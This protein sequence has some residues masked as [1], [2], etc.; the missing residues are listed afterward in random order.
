MKEVEWR[1]VLDSRTSP[2]CFPAETI[3]QAL[4]STEGL[5]R[6]WYEGKMVVIT[7]AKGHKLRGT[8]NHPILTASGWLPLHEIQPGEQVFNAH[9]SEVGK[10]STD[11]NVS[12]PTSLGAISDALNHPAVSDVSVKRS[13][14][15]DFHG[16]GMG[17][18][19]EVDIVKTKGDLRLW[20]ETGID[21][22]VVHAL[23][24]ARHCRPFLT[25][26]G[27]FA[28]HF[29][30]G[31]PI[32]QPPEVATVSVEAL[33]EPAFGSAALQTVEDDAGPLTRVEHRNSADLIS[34]D[35]FIKLAPSQVRSD[36]SV[37]EQGGD[38]GDGAPVFFCELPGGDA[39]R[40]LSD[41][42]VSV[43]IEDAACHVYNLQTSLGYYIAG[44]LIVHNCQSR[45]GQRYPVGEG[46]RPPA[47]PGCRSIVI[48][49]LDGSPPP[50][51][52]TYPEWI[53]RQPNKVQD[54]IL[55]PTR[56]ELLRQGRFKVTE[57]TDTTGDVIPLTRLKQRPPPPANA[58]RKA[59]DAIAL[60]RQS[61][62]DRLILARQ[63][64]GDTAVL[65]AQAVRDQV[66]ITAGDI[67]Q[68]LAEM[69]MALGQ[70][71]AEGRMEIQRGIDELQLML[72]GLLD[73]LR[74]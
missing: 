51:R 62:A 71:S 31:A 13:A 74:R 9:L 36:A 58:V 69:R 42:V 11:K 1:S 37:L 29:L 20:R 73:R 4:G 32:I 5:Y 60:A 41:Y 72:Q 15:T 70:A 2:V 10:V 21:K 43:R 7:T 54:E 65:T 27:L 40:V 64:A 25:N 28:R 57:F 68:K 59:Q 19:E 52:E 44:G 46:P 3:V 55:G 61:A 12:V 23:F 18:D 56:A 50:Q 34:A 22:H 17:P 49:I 35:K 53:E 47:H 6:R 8:P 63:S 14:P 38:G 30:S 26:E 24:G 33:V 39:V 48:E 66:T 16:D 67:S 45:D